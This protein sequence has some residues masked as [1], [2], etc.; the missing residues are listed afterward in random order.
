MTITEPFTA[1]RTDGDPA[2]WQILATGGQTAGVAMFGEAYLP[3]RTSGPGLHVHTREDEAIYVISGVMTF[4]VGDRRFEAGAGTLVWLPRQTP[5]VFANF[6][7][8]PVRAVGTATPAGL[9]AMFV[10]QAQYF[11]GLHGAP[12][13]R[14]IVEIGAKYGVQSLGP[15]LST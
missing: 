1:R 13:P 12:D 15:P 6:G 3:A 7:D 2:P 11:A 9:E 4:V 5:H 14:R 8:E 10:E